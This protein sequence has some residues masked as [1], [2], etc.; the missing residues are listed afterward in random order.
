VI[1]LSR[2]QKTALLAACMCLATFAF[3]QDN[4]ARQIRPIKLGT[5]GGNVND[6]SKAF[7]CS[8]TLGAL[9]TKGGTK[10]ILSNNHVLARADQA[11]VGEAISQPGLIDSGCRVSSADTVASFSESP[12]LGTRNVDAALAA[13]AGTEVDTT[14]AILD[15]G[16]PSSST[17]TPTVGRGVAKAGRTTGLTCGSIGSINTD[18]RVQ[19]QRGCNQGKKFTIS[20]NDQLV[21]NSSSFSAGGD[22]GSL[23]VT[24]D[25]AQPVGLLYAGSSTSTIGNPIADVVSALG[26]SF[27]GS[28]THA[29]SCP[30]GGPPAGA[31]RGVSQADLH[32]AI[33]AKNNNRRQ[34]FA[35]PAV[36]GV[37][38]GANAAGE[39]VVV[40]Y[41]ESGRAERF[42]PEFLDGVRT[43]VIRTD[44]FTAYGWNEK[45]PGVSC[46]KND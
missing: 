35:D 41:L 43:Q 20:Y 37:G 31:G 28:S 14:G 24:S 5:S 17:A 6:I 12:T 23:I 13:V 46:K 4:Q 3:S 33:E 26:I 1:A 19:Y 21:V 27:V 32:R 30:T 15:I 45:L 34:L 7:C 42:I 9:V 10:Y 2:I 18:V 38:V 16:V 8:G 22:S 36:Q 11:G 40:I 25:T 39:A 29:V 44:R